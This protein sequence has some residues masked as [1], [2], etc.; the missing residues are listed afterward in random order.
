MQEMFNMNIYVDQLD[1]AAFDDDL[2]NDD[3]IIDFE[4]VQKV[5]H[6]LEKLIRCQVA[7]AVS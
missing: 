6:D 5:C 1:C 4:I 7:S 3:N 2:S